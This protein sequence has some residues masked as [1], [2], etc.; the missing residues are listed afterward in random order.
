VIEYK[1]FPEFVAS[2][3]H[4]KCLRADGH[5]NQRAEIQSTERGG[6]DDESRMISSATHVFF[7]LP[8]N[9]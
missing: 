9:C 5:M 3:K 1:L 2:R 8:K 4:I 6:V 7:N